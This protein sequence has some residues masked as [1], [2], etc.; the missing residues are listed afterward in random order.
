MKPLVRGLLIGTSSLA[1]LGGTL[2]GTGQWAYN[3]GMKAEE[4]GPAGFEAAKSNLI[5]A[6]KLLN[7][8]AA[9]QLGKLFK[10]GNLAP[11]D[12]AAAF[13]WFQA[14]ARRG[15]PDA[16]T[17]EAKALWAG[18]GTKFDFDSGLVAM[19]AAAEK[20]SPDAMA[21]LARMCFNPPY[22]QGF[23]RDFAQGILWAKK[24]SNLGSP[25]GMFL[26]GLCYLAGNGVDQDT[27]LGTSW[28]ER[29]ADAGSPQACLL[30]GMQYLATESS[31]SFLEEKFNYHNPLNMDSAT[32]AIINNYERADI[33]MNRKNCL[34]DSNP[35][36]AEPY[37]QRASALGMRDADPYLVLLYESGNDEEPGKYEKLIQVLERMTGHGD[38][39]ATRL[40]GEGYAIGLGG[41]PI[42]PRKGAYF[43]NLASSR[44]DKSATDLLRRIAIRDQESRNPSPKWSRQAFYQ[45]VMGKSQEQVL[46]AVGRPDQTNQM[47]HTFWDY[48]GKTY[49]PVSGKTD[50]SADIE[51][52]GGVV[53]RVT[54]G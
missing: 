44:G 53:D 9:F 7:G 33:A 51:F 43:L 31:D 10:D 40:L 5:L 25:D 8:H 28:L 29:G 20:G 30:L 37:L 23:K 13:T 36:K 38:A 3:R 15:D 21:E 46:A 32:M 17:E 42:D 39:W 49:D 6:H 12:P 22:D 26:I 52:T 2:F 34:H 41:I 45:L 48:M 1:V 35:R 16:L 47:H 4:R 50:F 19:K 14:G 54:F 11:A 24:A 27:K 18:Q